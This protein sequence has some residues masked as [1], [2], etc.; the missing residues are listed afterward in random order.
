MTKGNDLAGP[1][2]TYRDRPP[3][4]AVNSSWV[5]VSLCGNN[6]V[7]YLVN[8]SSRYRCCVELLGKTARGYVGI[9]TCD[10]GQGTWDRGQG[11][12]DMGHGT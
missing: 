2:I 11:T 8:N 4:T 6:G 10:M 12:G 7:N 3:L 1:D 9:V 5:A